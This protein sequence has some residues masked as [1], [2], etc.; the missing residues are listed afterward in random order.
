VRVAGRGYRDGVRSLEAM[1]ESQLDVERP[2]SAAHVTQLA[3]RHVYYVHCPAT[4]RAT[5]FC[6][7]R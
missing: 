5:E 1:L 3:A 6:M 4:H 2:R 7:V